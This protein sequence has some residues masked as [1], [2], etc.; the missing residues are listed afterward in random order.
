[1]TVI[2]SHRAGGYD[3]SQTIVA[4]LWILQSDHR[5][6]SSEINFATTFRLFRSPFANFH[7]PLSFSLATR[8]GSFASLS[9]T[10]SKLSAAQRSRLV[11]FSCNYILKISHRIEQFPPEL[12]F[13]PVTPKLR[14]VDGG[15]KIVVKRD[16]RTVTAPRRKDWKSQTTFCFKREK[17]CFS[18]VIRQV[19]T[20]CG[21][22]VFQTIKE[23]GL[24]RFQFRAFL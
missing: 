21:M 11:I 12:R 13:I 7:G 19:S 4:V 9:R 23:T 5:G 24:S 20:R 22:Y 17:E 14:F 2:R 15:I 18:N 10:F 16:Q 1:M 3:F 8:R 6:H